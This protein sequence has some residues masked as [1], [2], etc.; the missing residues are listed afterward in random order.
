MSSTEQPCVILDCGE[1]D[2]VRMTV[3]VG[4]FVSMAQ[5]SEAAEQ[6]AQDCP[7][8]LAIVCRA[9]DSRRPTTGTLDD[10]RSV[11]RRMLSVSQRPALAPRHTTPEAPDVM[12][13]EARADQPGA[14]AARAPNPKA[15]APAPATR[16]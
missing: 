8:A 6:L 14:S 3:Q 5:A 4:P 9:P 10:A 16:N 11:A 2:G 15:K 1:V 7:G 12:P 13:R